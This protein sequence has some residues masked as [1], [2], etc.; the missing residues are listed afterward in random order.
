MGDVFATVLRR[1][2]GADQLAAAWPRTRRPAAGR[3]RARRVPSL[4]PDLRPVAELAAAPAAPGRRGGQV[5]T[6]DRAPVEWLIDSS[7]VQY[8][9]NGGD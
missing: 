4:P 8:A 9:A 7:I 5:Y 2:D 6:D 1:P 3:L